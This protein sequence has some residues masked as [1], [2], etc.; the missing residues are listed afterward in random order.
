MRMSKKQSFLVCF[1]VLILFS[2][3]TAN[4]ES[5]IREFK[6]QLNN[7]FP[8]YYQPV[9]RVYTEQ[10]DLAEDPRSALAELISLQQAQIEK[11]STTKSKAWF[12][13]QSRESKR[14]DK[15]LAELSFSASPY[16]TKI[17]NWYPRKSSKVNASGHDFSEHN[18]VVARI[19]T[20][21]LYTS[22]S[23]RD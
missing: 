20:C 3:T 22:P 8:E 16:C 6:K 1:C 15:I 2:Y 9:K 10:I 14:A 11:V 13:M 23:P 17:L 4:A 21:L 18:C 5:P 7:P 12:H 19:Y